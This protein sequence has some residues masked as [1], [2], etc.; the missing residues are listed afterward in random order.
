MAVRRMAN[1]AA[2]SGHPL[3]QRIAAGYRSYPPR[4]PVLPSRAR[5]AAGDPIVLHK[6]IIVGT[7]GVRLGALD[8][9][10][11]LWAGSA[12]HAC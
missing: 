10:A 12:L 11:R 2:V 9:A 4:P 1:R 7:G 3:P 5:L 8:Q 6:S